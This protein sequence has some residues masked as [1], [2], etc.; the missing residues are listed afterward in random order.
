[1]PTP[2]QDPTDWRL[3]VKYIR[4]KEDLDDK[5]VVEHLVRESANYTLIGNILYR[6]GAAGALMRCIYTSMGKHL[7]EEIHAEQ[8]EVHVA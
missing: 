7:L 8:C 5:V 2:E 6:Q 3:P 4:N 1:V